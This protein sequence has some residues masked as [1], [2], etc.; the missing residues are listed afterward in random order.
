MAN[1]I[2][3]R[4]CMKTAW[5]CMLIEILNGSLS[6]GGDD[7]DG[8]KAY[9]S[10]FRH[11]AANFNGYNFDIAQSQYHSKEDIIHD[12]MSKDKKTGWM[13]VDAHVPR[14]HWLDFLIYLL[15]TLN[16]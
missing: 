2:E 7:D 5:S 16:A 9:C 10:A 15:C 1:L 6:G 4:L 8:S 14:R 12:M 13:L 11:F 3:A